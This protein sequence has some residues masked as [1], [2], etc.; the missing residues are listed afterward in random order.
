[1]IPRAIYEYI[2][3]RIK[4]ILAIFPNVRPDAE[5]ERLFLFRLAA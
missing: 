5:Y 4:A 1:M 3:Y 2:L